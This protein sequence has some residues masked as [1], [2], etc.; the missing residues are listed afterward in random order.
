MW[1]NSQKKLKE[2][3]NGETMTSRKLN[4]DFIAVCLSYTCL[5]SQVNEF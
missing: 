2:L 3:V 5:A 4:N 1:N